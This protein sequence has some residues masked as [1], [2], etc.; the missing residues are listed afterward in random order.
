VGVGIDERVNNINIMISANEFM[1][2]TVL[3]IKSRKNAQ[4]WQFDF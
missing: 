3:G 2:K 4:K 1:L